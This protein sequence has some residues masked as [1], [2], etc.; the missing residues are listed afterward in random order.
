[1]KEIKV[2]CLCMESL[3][4]TKKKGP[5]SILIERKRT[6]QPLLSANKGQAVTS[7]ITDAVPHEMI[8]ISQWVWQKKRKTLRVPEATHPH[9]EELTQLESLSWK[10]SHRLSPIGCL[11][12]GWTVATAA[13][14]KTSIP[15][16]M[17][18]ITT[19]T[20]NSSVNFFYLGNY[21]GHIHQYVRQCDMSPWTAVSLSLVFLSDIIWYYKMCD[22]MTDVN[23]ILWLHSPHQY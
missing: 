22:V 19:A 8:I 13:N 18:T 1:M 6:C 4:Q 23:L 17:H 14:T 9:L 2:I 20:I 3:L 10:C 16:W 15:K 11:P 5:L 12:L 7:Q 21:M